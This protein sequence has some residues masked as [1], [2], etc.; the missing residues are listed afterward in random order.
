MSRNLTTT[1]KIAGVIGA[2][3]VLLG[4]AACSKE[5]SGTATAAEVEKT[6][7]KSTSEKSGKSSKSSKSSKTTDT[8][9]S[10]SGDSPSGGGDAAAAPD[11]PYS[12]TDGTTVKLDAPT[13][14]DN[15][16]GLLSH[17]TGRVLPFHIDNKSK[18]TLDLSST[19]TFAEIDCQGSDQ[20]VFPFEPLGGPEQLAPGQKGDY[21]LSVG[22]KK[23]DVGKNCTITIPFETTDYSVDVDVATFTMTLT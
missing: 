10:T 17:E 22:L 8:D 2:F 9:E 18:W 5:V 19:A 6:T 4:S 14:N 21:Q 7:E 16:S 11:Q 20:Y 12:Y 23:S 1:K 13:V 3:A 15:I